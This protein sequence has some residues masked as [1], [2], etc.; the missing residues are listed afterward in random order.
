MY[1]QCCHFKGLTL[2]P[3]THQCSEAL[4]AKNAVATNIT[5]YV[6]LVVIA[7]PVVNECFPIWDFFDMVGYIAEQCIKVA[8]SNIC[9]EN[10]L[11]TYYFILHIGIIRCI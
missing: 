8:I 5:W 10:Y 7:A 11:K 4:G 3:F 2:M 1:T 9:F 6:W